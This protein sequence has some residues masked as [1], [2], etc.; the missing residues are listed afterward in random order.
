MIGAKIDVIC[1]NGGN[2]KEEI[3][4]SAE[5]WKRQGRVGRIYIS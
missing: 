5:G 1:R 3:I 4:C 2:T